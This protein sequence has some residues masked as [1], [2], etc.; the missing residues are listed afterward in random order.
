M[1]LKQSI[2]ASAKILQESFKGQN[3]EGNIYEW[4]FDL[5]SSESKEINLELENVIEKA[6][7]SAINL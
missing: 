6:D 4:K 1:I 5:N 7:C 2:P 3:G